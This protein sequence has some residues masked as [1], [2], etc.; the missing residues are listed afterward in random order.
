MMAFIFGSDFSFYFD[1]KEMKID[2]KTIDKINANKSK[3]IIFCWIEV[4]R[5]LSV[6][7]AYQE[8]RD[9]SR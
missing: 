2:T 7:R 8:L 9:S 6:P 5:D 4:P 3:P 1:A